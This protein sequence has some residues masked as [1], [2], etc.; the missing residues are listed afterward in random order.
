[1]AP[2]P[3]ACDSRSERPFCLDMSLLAENFVQ[4]EEAEIAGLSEEQIQLEKESKA[5]E[6]CGLT[7]YLPSNPAEYC[8]ER[9]CYN[10]FTCS[11]QSSLTVYGQWTGDVYGRYAGNGDSDP[12]KLAIITRDA[13]PDF[14][15]IEFAKLQLV[16]PEADRD[17]LRIVGNLRQVLAA[18]PVWVVIARN[19][20][21][22]EINGTCP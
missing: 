9:I 13:D 7:G 8:C 15:P 16:K 6:M 18:R 21:D 20:S 19:K 12:T 10:D 17:T 14:D 22:I 1:M 5:L 3:P 4:L 2:A 11:D